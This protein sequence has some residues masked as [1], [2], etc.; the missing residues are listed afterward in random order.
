M[1]LCFSIKFVLLLQELGLNG[2]RLACVR[3]R[4]KLTRQQIATDLCNQQVLET[5]QMF[6][7]YLSSEVFTWNGLFVSL[8]THGVGVLPQLGTDSPILSVFL[9]C[10]SS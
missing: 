6:C 9:Q 8:V 4:V 5:S 7:L 10:A 3:R 1:A 2:L